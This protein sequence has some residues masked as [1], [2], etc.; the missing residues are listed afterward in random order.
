M[1]GERVQYYEGAI[2]FRDEKN[3]LQYASTIEFLI[4]SYSSFNTT[5][6]GYL[7]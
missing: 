7:T 1:F 4:T 5:P 3:K 6:R 2:E